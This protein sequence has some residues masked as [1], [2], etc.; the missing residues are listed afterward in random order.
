VQL[1]TCP[2]MHHGSTPMPHHNTCCSKKPMK[3]IDEIPWMNQHP[4]LVPSW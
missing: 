2:S 3:L 1:K 4:H